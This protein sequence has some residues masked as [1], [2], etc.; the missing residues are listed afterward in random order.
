LAGIGQNAEMMEL[1]P[2]GRQSETALAVQRGAGRLLRELGFAVLPEFTLRTGRRADLIAIGGDGKIWIAEIKSSLEDFRAD[3]KW[4]EYGE[5]CDRFFFAVPQDFNHDIL[6]LEAGLI[7][8]DQWGAEVLRE[9]P[10]FSLHASRRKSVTL[11]FARVAGQRLHGL[12]D[13]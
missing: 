2:D 12:Y 5:F 6:P 11:Q 8:A 7:V 4:P 9:P 10:E 13:P 3:A 1:R